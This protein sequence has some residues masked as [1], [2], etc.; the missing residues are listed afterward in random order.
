VV[1]GDIEYVLPLEDKNTL[2]L[3]RMMEK[4]Q[5]VARADATVRRLQEHRPF[6]LVVRGGN[7]ICPTTWSTLR[8]IASTSRSPHHFPACWHDELDRYEG[9]FIQRTNS[10]KAT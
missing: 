6:A 8:Q 2:L 7:P 1:T 5:Q 10:L 9:E 3:A 4:E